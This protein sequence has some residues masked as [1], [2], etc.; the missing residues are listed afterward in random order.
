[1]SLSRRTILA[2]SAAFAAI[3]AIARPARA[4]GRLAAGDAELT[5]VSDGYMELPLGFA[6]PDAPAEALKQL[7]SQAGQPT[8]RLVN[9]CNV[10]I[11]RRGDRI[12]VFDVGAG[13][14]F[15]PTTGRLV[16][17]LAE[18][19]VDPEAV[20]DVI[21][22]H[23]HPDHIWGVTDDFDELLF[24]NAEYQISQAE[25]DFWSSPDAVDAMPEERR[26]FVPGAQTRF[27][28]IEDRVSFFKPGD[29]VLDGVEAVGTPGHTPGHTS[30][31][32]HGGTDPVLIAGDAVTNVV[33]SLGRP[34]WPSGADQDAELGVRTR[35]ALL[36][37]VATEKTRIIGF[38]FPHPAGGAIERAGNAYRFVPA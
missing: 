22:T 36:D 2:G 21:F 30:F 24:P 37:R 7:L 35:L 26:N 19:G 34:D 10:T 5:V 23:A 1:M 16:D 13:G 9:D 20:T 15:L 38:H 14:R 33:V 29:S 3:G 12:A 25:W 28:A 31:M 17:N 18:A 4:I 32:V 11:L 8:D 27:D 6:M